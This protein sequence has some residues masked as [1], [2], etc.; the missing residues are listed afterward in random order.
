M[1]SLKLGLQNSP[2]KEQ[3]MCKRKP[4]VA[5]IRKLSCLYGSHL[6]SMHLLKN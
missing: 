1:F 2:V 4:F 6:L 3:N 5:Y